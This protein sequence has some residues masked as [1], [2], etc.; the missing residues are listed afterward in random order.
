VI[1]AHK[2]GED[3]LVEVKINGVEV[4]FREFE[5]LCR[6]GY[7]EVV[8]KTAR[9]IFNEHYQ[10]ALSSS[11]EALENIN[12]SA[13]DLAASLDAQTRKAMGLPPPSED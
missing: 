1:A 12:N 8:M 4:D 9:E 6:Q 3:Y 5:S 13:K 10:Q 2:P 7:S 11:Y